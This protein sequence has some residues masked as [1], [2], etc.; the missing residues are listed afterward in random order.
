MYSRI[1]FAPDFAKRFF[2]R[3][4]QI[5]EAYLDGTL[6]KFVCIWRKISRKSRHKEDSES[7]S[8]LKLPHESYFRF[9][10]DAKLGFYLVLNGMDQLTDVCGA[11]S[12]PVDHETAMLF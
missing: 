1:L 4:T 2:V 5:Y 10:A 3:C 9:Q 11:G 6:I 12:S 8:Y 7:T